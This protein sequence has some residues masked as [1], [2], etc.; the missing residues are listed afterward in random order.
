M[1]SI[2][3]I[4]KD[5]RFETNHRSIDEGEFAITL[6]A[7]EHVEA[8]SLGTYGSVAVVLPW[9][10]YR[11]LFSPKNPSGGLFPLLQQKAVVVIGPYSYFNEVEDLVLQGAVTFLA[12]PASQSTISSVISEVV[13]LQNL[14]SKLDAPKVSAKYSAA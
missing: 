5:P 9:T 2:S 4:S 3:V 8:T 12:T 1:K 10:G 6:L 13:R 11:E 14:S 7:A